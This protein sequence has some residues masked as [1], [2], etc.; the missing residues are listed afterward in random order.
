MWM[1][2]SEPTNTKLYVFDG[3]QDVLIGAFDLN[4]GESVNTGGTFVEEQPPTAPYKAVWFESDTG[5]T[6]IRYKNPD[7]SQTWVEAAGGG[8]GG[9]PKGI[10]SMWSGTIATIPSGWYLCDG[11]NNTPDLRDRFIL[12]AGGATA[13]LISGGYADTTLPSHNHGGG[14]FSGNATGTTSTDA[15]H[16]HGQALWVA[17]GNPGSYPVGFRDVHENITGSHRTTTDGAHSHTFSVAIS[18]GVNISLEGT[19]PVGKNI[20]P[21][22]SLAYIMK[23]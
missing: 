8:G 1:D 11:S 18:G 13:P 9:V 10:I 7:D 22:F 3:T 15:G 19:S 12:G 5:R 17:N 14:T 6:F 16:T 23:G 2:D 20:P 4:T 21:F